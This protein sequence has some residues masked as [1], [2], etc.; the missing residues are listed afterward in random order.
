[1]IENLKTQAT[2]DSSQ[3]R[4]LEWVAVLSNLSFT[5]LYMNQS[6]WSFTMGILGPLFLL[7]LSWR[8]KL[9]AEPVLQVVYIVSAVVGWLN[10][11]GGWSTLQLSLKT[12][13]MLF[14]LS[15]G[16]AL[17][18]GL[19][20]KRYTS[21]NFPLMD[22]LMASWGMLA[23]WLM[24]YQIHECWL[25]LIAVNVLSFF[26]YFKRRLFAAACMFAIYFILSIDGYF[27]MHWFEL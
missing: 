2:S 24:M 13:L 18:W 11:Q 27:R 12:H 22:A 26:M 23:T 3:R 14:F 9:Y 21:A 20:L 1:L 19:G 8:E 10:V 16:L 17:P 4:I 7:I 6:E 25:Y 5:V 15:T